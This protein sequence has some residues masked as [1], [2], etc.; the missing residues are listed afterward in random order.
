MAAPSDSGRTTPT[1]QTRAQKRAALPDMPDDVTANELRSRDEIKRYRSHRNRLLKEISEPAY[2][3][4]DAACRR[5]VAGLAYSSKALGSRSELIVCDNSTRAEYLALMMALEDAD[6]ASLP[7]PIEFRVDSTALVNYRVARK[8][9][10]KQLRRWLDMM[11]KVHA[12]WRL[13]LLRRGDNMAAN[14]LARSAL[15]QWER[16]A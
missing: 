9:D 4:T 2:V 5:G 16:E 12:T 7:G 8:P 11:F 6:K 1:R 15:D 14:D 3:N 10:F 13:T